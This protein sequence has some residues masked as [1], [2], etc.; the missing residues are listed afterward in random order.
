MFNVN[1]VFFYINLVLIGNSWHQHTDVHR[2]RVQQRAARIYPLRVSDAVQYDTHFIVPS[3]R[4]LHG[5][6]LPT[7]REITRRYDTILENCPRLGSEVRPTASWPWLVTFSFI[8]LRD[9]EVTHTH[10]KDRGQRSVGSKDRVETN[11]RTDGRANAM[12]KDV[13]VLR[14]AQKLVVASLLYRTEPK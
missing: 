11:G 1:K 8:H 13:R 6:G 5:W 2:E 4:S 12:G 3:G 9:T 10:A 7:V 14:C